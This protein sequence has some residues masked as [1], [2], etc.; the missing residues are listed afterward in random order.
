[1][2]TA[3][4]WWTIVWPLLV[5]VQITLVGV[6]AFHAAVSDVVVAPVYRKF[7]GVFVL[8]VVVLPRNVVAVTIPE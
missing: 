2:K 8:N 1:M 6:G 7:V 3:F 5:V 4:R